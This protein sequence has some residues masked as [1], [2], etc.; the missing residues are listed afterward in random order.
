MQEG[1]NEPSIRRVF[2]DAAERV[3]PGSPQQSHE[4]G[5][6]LIVGMVGGRD[7]ASPKALGHLIERRVAEG[8]PRFL[9]RGPQSAALPCPGTLR[10]YPA[11]LE[12]QVQFEGQRLHAGRV[13]VSLFA[14]ETVMH[15]GEP[16]G[17]LFQA[18]KRVQSVSEDRGVHST[19]DRHQ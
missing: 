8:T 7:G 17:Q 2:R 9:E 19:G 16:Q 6:R 13:C 1:P 15:V 11:L 18:G 5:F 4:D 3:W 14:A 12:R 10:V